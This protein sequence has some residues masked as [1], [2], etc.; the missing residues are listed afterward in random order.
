MLLY[1]SYFIFFLV[2]S[3]GSVFSS[4][5][6]KTRFEQLLPVTSSS[7]VLIIFICGFLGNLHLGVYVVLFL[8]LSLYALSVIYIIREK[9]FYSV[10]SNIFTPAFFVFACFYFLF[11]FCSKGMLL[12]GY[13]EFSHW[14]DIVK[15]MVR[16]DDFGTNP[17]SNSQFP[18]YPPGMA[19]LQ[20]FFQK[21]NA[22]VSGQEFVESGLFVSYQIFTFSFFFPFLN[23]LSF[24]KFTLLICS[25]IVLFLSPLWFFPDTYFYIFID[26]YLSILSGVGL[27]SVFLIRERTPRY[28]LFVFSISSML[29]LAKSPGLFFAAVLIA[30]YI[31]DWIFISPLDLYPVSIRSRFLFPI[32]GILS[33]AVPKLVWSIQVSLS[34]CHVSNSGKID[35]KDLFLAIIRR[36]QTY[37]QSIWTDFYDRFL[38]TGVELG[39]TGITIN[40]LLLFFLFFIAIYY[41]SLYAYPK[42]SGSSMKRKLLL[43]GVSFQTLVYIVGMAISYMYKFSEYEGSILASFDRY[44][45]VAYL[46]IW[47]IIILISLSFLIRQDSSKNILCIVLLAAVILVSP[48]STAYDY[49]MKSHVWVAQ[50]VRSWYQ[51]LADTINSTDDGSRI[52]ILSQSDDEY[53]Y[54]V[55][56]YCISPHPC[57]DSYCLGKSRFEGDIWSQSYSAFEFWQVLSDGY[58]YLAIFKLDDFFIEN[59]SCLFADPESISQN[60]LYYINKTSNL[61]EKY[62]PLSN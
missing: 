21:L 50:K 6:Y 20:H 11:I 7:I 58:D 52:Y 30:V 37:R 16:I 25:F 34:N 46:G 54:M 1:I 47:I 24:K 13:D 60:T 41:I 4:A 42:T 10:L 40:Y 39:N 35:F 5:L 59:Y 33:V 38:S 51:Y 53:D 14:G 57:N 45:K 29:V 48:I 18:S 19:I 17:D 12:S 23:G 8:C 26:P 62:D 61:L 15:T 3:S 44:I 31:I 55:L 36:N 22:L 43:A 56:R 28:S 27:A 2:L 49:T 32:A 9:S